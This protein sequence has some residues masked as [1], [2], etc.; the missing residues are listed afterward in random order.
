[1]HLIFYASDDRVVST[2]QLKDGNPVL[3]IE[4]VISP[5]INLK[6]E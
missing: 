5:T 1:M 3:E 2:S 6:V 4:K